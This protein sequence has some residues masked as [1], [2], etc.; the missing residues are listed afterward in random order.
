MDD[1]IVANAGDHLFVVVNASMRDQDI[2]H[3]ASHLDGIEVTEI[4]NRALI[5][6]QKRRR[7]EGGFPGAARIQRDLAQGW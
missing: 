3:M 6:M 7:E 1:L 4:F 5:A 2:P